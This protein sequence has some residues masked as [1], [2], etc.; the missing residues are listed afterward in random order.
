MSTKNINNNRGS[1]FGKVSGKN[2]E[3]RTSLS[4]S[5]GSELIASGGVVATPGDGY[6]YVAFTGIGTFN[7]ALTD[8]YKTC[9]I[10]AIGG[11]G[12][13]GGTPGDYTGGGGAGGLVLVENLPISSL[14]NGKT[15]IATITVGAA[16]AANARGGDT[17]MANPGGSIYILAKGG[18]RGGA[19]V[20][21][22][23]LKSGGSGGGDSLYYVN[24][25]AGVGTQPFTTQI[26]GSGTLSLNLG[27][28]GGTGAGYGAPAPTYPDAPWGFGGGSGGGGAGAPGRIG[29]GTVPFHGD[30][31]IGTHISWAT[32]ANHPLCRTYGDYAGGGG[33][34]AWNP[35]S[36]TNVENNPVAGL[37]GVWNGS[38]RVGT[39]ATFGAGNGGY[40][41][42]G[43]PASEIA[44]TSGAVR[45]GGGGGGGYGAPNAQ[46]GG[47]G[48]CIIRIPLRPAD[49]ITSA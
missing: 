28:P 24:I 45:S 48:F 23:P 39:S 17:S 34:A 36:P 19:Y 11:G 5:V 16:G 20:P 8:V 47:S 7:V 1:V 3:Y 35:A 42:A 2:I 4:N 6:A 14:V 15:G 25:G 13:G 18:G 49:S 40:Y 33:G 46:S 43:P 31:G 27:N 44:G 38:S 9:D 10:L 37:G 21:A 41:W 22:D 32:A 29:G 12:G 30:G 26:V